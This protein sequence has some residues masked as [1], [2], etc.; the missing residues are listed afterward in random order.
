MGIY[1][2]SHRSFISKSKSKEDVLSRKI[3]IG[4][5]Y[6]FVCEEMVNVVQ[7]ISRKQHLAIV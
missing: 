5:M 7:S 3:K 1:N 2:L 4:E 6:H